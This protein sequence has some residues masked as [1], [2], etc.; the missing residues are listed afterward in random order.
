MMEQACKYLSEGVIF[1]F[2][3]HPSCQIQVFNYPKL[4]IRITSEPIFRLLAKCDAAYTSS[5]TSAAVD[6]YNAGIPVVSLR[7]PS[8]LNLSPLRDLK[9]ALFASTPKEL[10]K[11]LKKA[12]S[13]I[14][15]KKKTRNLFNLDT[16][17]PRWRNLLQRT[18]VK[19]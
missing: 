4:K 13:Q 1:I 7:D 8:T 2:K 14:R 16:R 19:M 18:K 5:V 3:P 17:L 10:A 9:G 15:P 11:M 6:V 12:T